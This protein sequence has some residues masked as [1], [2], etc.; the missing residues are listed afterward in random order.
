MMTDFNLFE[1]SPI[2]TI[3]LDSSG[4]I[5]F[6]NKNTNGLFYEINMPENI[7]NISLLFP[8]F[9]LQ[10]PK[11]NQILNDKKGH[12]VAI[13]IET[14]NYKDQNEFY[15]LFLQKT[16]QNKFVKKKTVCNSTEI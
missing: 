10:N 3:V 2:P 13:D 11:K 14:V 5:I 15:L 9:D 6:R 8:F 1:H 16:N 4:N 12:P 7:N